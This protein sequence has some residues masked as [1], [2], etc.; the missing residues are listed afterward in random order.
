MKN[1]I[2]PPQAVHFNLYWE[3][4][5]FSIF[6][7]PFCGGLVF[8]KVSISNELIYSLILLCPVLLRVNQLRAY[9]FFPA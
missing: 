8:S 1:N 3:I 2:Q 9:L 5:G 6:A 7:F 4:W